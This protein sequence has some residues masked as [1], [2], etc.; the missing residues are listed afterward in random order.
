MLKL[1]EQYRRTYDTSVD[2]Q[3][4]WQ[5]FNQKSA[6][7][8]AI[9]EGV[10][11]IVGQVSAKK[12][13]QAFN[14]LRDTERELELWRSEKDYVTADELLARGLDPEKYG[15]TTKVYNSATE[16]FEE[17]PVMQ[18][19]MDEV[20]PDLYDT[21][22]TEAARL[23]LEHIPSRHRSR[24]FTDKMQN[25]VKENAHSNRLSANQRLIKRYK[26]EDLADAQEAMQMGDFE[27]AREIIGS[28][29]NLSDE[30][31]R[32]RLTLIDRQEE[33]DFVVDLLNVENPT[34]AVVRE[35][36]MVVSQLRNNEIPM[37]LPDE[38]RYSL[39]NQ[40]EA[41]VKQHHLSS[42]ATE[43]RQY[44]QNYNDDMLTA[45]D[46]PY[47]L[48]DE[49]I[50]KR[51]AEGYYGWKNSAQ[52]ARS[53]KER[54]RSARKAN[55]QK[56]VDFSY[57]KGG[58]VI[59]R[60]N[61]GMVKLGNLYYEEGLKQIMETA[62]AEGWERPQVEAAKFNLVKGMAAGNQFIPD[63]FLYDMEIS[64]KSS[65][66]EILQRAE[67][68]KTLRQIS[69]KAV[70]EVKTKWTPSL[71]AVESQLG[72]D[73]PAQQAVFNVMSWMKIPQDEKKVLMESYRQQALEGDVAAVLQNTVNEQFQQNLGGLF[74]TSSY[75]W[76][77]PIDNTEAVMGKVKAYVSNVNIS[78]GM[79]A[80][81]QT[82]TRDYLP[83]Y[84]G[85]VQQ[86]G[87][88][89]AMDMMSNGAIVTD[90]NGQH[91]LMYHP[92]SG[93]KKE[94]YKALDGYFGELNKAI[95]T[96]HGW[97]NGA[98]HIETPRDWEVYRNNNMPI[99]YQ[100][101]RTNGET[102]EDMELELLPPWQSI[103]LAEIQ[104]KSADKDTKLL[105]SEAK[106]RG[107]NIGEARAQEIIKEK[108]YRNP[109]QVARTRSAQIAR[110]VEEEQR[111]VE[112]DTKKKLTPYERNQF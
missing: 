79:V 88:A 70:N 60:S 99:P 69:P 105:M 66:A 30:E 59:P 97:E 31:R 1:P 75:S 62:Q 104:D 32:D 8:A 71:I 41:K 72:K 67:Q 78:P 90:L 96:R 51:E 68:L 47:A 4:A 52:K 49:M 83:I 44:E 46:N 106:Q 50:D 73:V 107:Q 92:P 33:I 87:R 35:Q 91:E 13:N 80:K 14:A 95:D 85:N 21:T 29:A 82:I 26:A 25:Y 42:A 10:Q 38:V 12:E 110:S 45:M 65:P 28:M 63:G 11:N 54:M 98:Y 101:W 36:E 9:N 39:A 48:T 37:N 34:E 27:N 18:Y 81:H 55:Q 5:E 102:G 76:F 111:Q 24:A 40:L 43:Q 16:Q 84:N 108:G 3:G 2:T 93:T 17:S 112:E 53:I 74:D 19:H 23:N 15:G 86:A 22:M 77:T 58:G 64:E 20:Y 56:S 6:A 103:N 89:A 100:I 109:S 57:V 94:I 7:L 61:E